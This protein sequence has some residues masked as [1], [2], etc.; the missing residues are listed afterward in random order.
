M[1]TAEE[2]RKILVR[3]PARKVREAARALDADLAARARDTEQALANGDRLLSQ[4][5][6]QLEAAEAERDRL[7][8]RVAE[9]EAALRE[10]R[11]L[12]AV[13]HES[14]PWY[15]EDAG[16][17]AEA[18][19]ARA[20]AALTGDGGGACDGSSDCE[21]TVHLH[22]CYSDDGTNCDHPSEHAAGD[23]GGA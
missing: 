3:W 12:A 1:V 10:T 15:A 19:L 5:G 22:G 17:D 16:I 4:A 6:R 21:A 18:V 20:R 9:L 14:D 2:A 8:R 11:N 23:G 13:A 7:A